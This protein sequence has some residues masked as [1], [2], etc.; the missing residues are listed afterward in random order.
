M[1]HVNSTPLDAFLIFNLLVFLPT[2]GNLRGWIRGSKPARAHANYLHEQDQCRYVSVS[3]RNSHADT[4][5]DSIYS[6]LLTSGK[7]GGKDLK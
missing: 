1:L 2:T 6:I 7:A 5:V 3:G 4:T